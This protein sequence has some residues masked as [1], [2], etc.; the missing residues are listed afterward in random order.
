[1]ITKQ[2]LDQPYYAVD[3]QIGSLA[4]Y[5]TTLDATGPLTSDKS[6]LYRIN[7]SYE[8]NGA[9]FGSFIDNTHAEN[10]SS[11]PSSNGISTTIVG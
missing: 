6:W 2:P 5:R 10:I 11:R 4:E 7:M 8:N 1:M 3:Q 9:P